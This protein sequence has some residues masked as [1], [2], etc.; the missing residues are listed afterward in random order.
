MDLLQ[1]GDNL[2]PFLVSEHADFG[3]H[4]GMGDRAADV[5]RV[6]P[7]IEGHALSELLDAAVRRLVKHTAPRLAG[8]SCFRRDHCGTRAPCRRWDQKQANMFTVNTLRR[9]VNEPLSWAA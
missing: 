4:Q 6:Q 1:A 9:G 2:V 5:L 7:P 3:Q 8:Q